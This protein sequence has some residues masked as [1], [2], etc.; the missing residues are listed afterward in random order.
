MA[1][2]W[3]LSSFQRLFC[4]S[5]NFYF[6]GVRAFWAKL[7]KRLLW[8]KKHKYITFWVIIDKL[9]LLYFWVFFFFLLVFVVVFLCFCF[10]FFWRVGPK[11]SLF[12][13]SFRFL[14][15]L[16]FLGFSKKKT[17]FSFWIRAF[18]LIFQCLPLFLPRFSLPLFTLSLSL[19]LY[20]L[21]FSL[22]IPSLLS[23][24]LSCFLMFCFSF[25][26]SLFWVSWKN[27]IKLLN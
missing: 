18:L 13:G 23:F 10:C 7:S 27:N 17:C 19:S 22:F 15:F 11:P 26:P 9:I 5:P 4:W 6:V 21:V 12:F 24:F 8:T 20:L 2:S 3:P 16:C 25:L 14:F 1:V